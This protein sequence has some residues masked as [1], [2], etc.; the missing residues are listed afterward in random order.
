MGVETVRSKLAI[1]K[2]HCETVGRDYG[3]IEKTVLGTAYLAPEKMGTAEV[4]TQCRDMAAIG[5]QQIIFNMPNLH[6]IKPL[7][8]FGRDIIPAVAGL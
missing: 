7:E 3:Q 8:T 5:I 6:E 4:I 1:L 2:Q